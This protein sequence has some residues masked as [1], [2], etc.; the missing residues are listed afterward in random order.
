MA[1][2]IEKTLG[3][4]MGLMDIHISA[5]SKNHCDI[6][7]T[8][9]V[10]GTKY[11]IATFDGATY[12]IKHERYFNDVFIKAAKD[13]PNIHRELMKI[14]ETQRLLNDDLGVLKLSFDCFKR[15]F[16]IFISKKI[17]KTKQLLTDG[18]TER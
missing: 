6:F 10:T 2:L 13:R 12:S 9:S 14:F 3:D 8:D 7:A 15:R 11:H 1:Y 4:Y 16:H 17:K 18:F 5:R